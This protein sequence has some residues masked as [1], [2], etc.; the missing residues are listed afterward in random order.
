MEQTLLNFIGSLL[1]TWA[2]LVGTASVIV[3]SRVKWRASPMGRHLMA[4]MAVVALVLDLG[5]VRFI[6]GGDTWWFALLR[7][8]VFAGVPV[9]MTQR[10]VLQM[11]A[12]RGAA[13][14][15][16]KDA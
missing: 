5:I 4:Y 3:H 13:K 8:A 14:Q 9:V 10:L 15:T 2:G 1:L 16:K 6:T 11:K 12:Q 7:T